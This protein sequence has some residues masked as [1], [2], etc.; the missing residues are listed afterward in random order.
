MSE[1]WTRTR[2]P[3]G[4]SAFACVCVKLRNPSQS[5]GGAT[6]GLPLSKKEQTG[7]HVPSHAFTSSAGASQKLSLLLPTAYVSEQPTPRNVPL[8]GCWHGVHWLLLN[9]KKPCFTKLR[10]EI[11]TRR[12][13][14]SRTTMNAMYGWLSSIAWSQGTST[15]PRLH[16]VV[17]MAKAEVPVGKVPEWPTPV[18][19]LT[20]PRLTSVPGITFDCAAA[21]LA[22]AS[23]LNPI[24]DTRMARCI[25]RASSRGCRK[26]ILLWVLECDRRLPTAVCVAGLDR[27]LGFNRVSALRASGRRPP[28]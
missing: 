25:V 9:A 1:S 18:R 7:F 8:L 28:A 14:F 23:K 12:P 20:A 10:S 26:A 24:A 19:E 3:T 15:V 27:R 6:G 5:C 22:R 4:P 11:W 13:S 17:D 16:D 2:L 21:T